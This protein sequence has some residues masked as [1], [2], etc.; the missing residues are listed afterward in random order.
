MC[1]IFIKL[2]TL[3]RRAAGLKFGICLL[4]LRTIS[5]PQVLY[6]GF[7]TYGTRAHNGPLK[8]ILGTQRS[9][10]YHTFKFPLPDHRRH[11]VHNM[12]IYTDI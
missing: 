10:L 1:S 9:L 4:N 8:D 7:L 11:I 12:C 2:L 5:R 6:Q 3:K